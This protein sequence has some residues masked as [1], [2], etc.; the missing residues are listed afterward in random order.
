MTYTLM[1]GGNIYRCF[2]VFFVVLGSK[3]ITQ[4]QMSVLCHVS[5]LYEIMKKKKKKNRG[6]WVG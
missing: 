6:D 3:C 5:V 2:F 1:V 4:D